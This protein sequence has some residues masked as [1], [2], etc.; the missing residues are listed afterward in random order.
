MTEPPEVVNQVWLSV[1]P[2]GRA[3]PAGIRQG[4]KPFP[5][6]TLHSL[7]QAASPRPHSWLAV[8]FVILISNLHF[9]PLLLIF[10]LTMGLENKLYS[11]QQIVLFSK[12]TVQ[13]NVDAMSSGCILILLFGRK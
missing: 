12:I 13:D 2:C 11:L 3:L 8:L 1:F 7:P 5:Q 10:L 6:R 4:G 9:L